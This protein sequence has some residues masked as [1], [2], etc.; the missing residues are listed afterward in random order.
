MP[1][2]DKNPSIELLLGALLLNIKKRT[3]GYMRFDKALLSFWSANRA[4]KISVS[5]HRT[6]DLAD[7]LGYSIESDA[8]PLKR[9][10]MLKVENRLAD[11]ILSGKLVLSIAYL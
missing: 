5:H 3:T 11:L 9:F 10:I 4:N 1:Q 7:Q 6:L 2:P 8:S